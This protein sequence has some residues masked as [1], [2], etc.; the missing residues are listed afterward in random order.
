MEDNS[1]IYIALD[2]DILRTLATIY[3]YV[4]KGIFYDYKSSNNPHIKKNFNY[5]SKL[6]KYAQEDKIRL[7]VTTTPYHEVRHKTECISFIK[8]MC[9][10]PNPKNIL[11]QGDYQQKIKEL[12]AAYCGL[13]EP[14]DPT[15]PPPMH[16]C[17]VSAIDDCVPPNDAFVQA[18]AA[19][20]NA[21]LL[22]ANAADF[23]FYK[24]F[25]PDINAKVSKI[26]EINRRVLNICKDVGYK[27]ISRPFT[28]E[29]L[30]AILKGN[31][32]NYEFVKALDTTKMRAN[33][34][35]DDEE[36]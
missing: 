31:P 33:A 22:T 4:S 26:I 14:Y 3:P 19:V 34:P 16:P 13:N 2:S 10:V 23:I 27:L 35:T 1:H 24:N 18:E 36:K 28:I 12:A 17:Y 29:T 25:R 20:E 11:E 7:M 15:N 21:I 6:I 5:L 30:A 9:Y 8:D 32:S